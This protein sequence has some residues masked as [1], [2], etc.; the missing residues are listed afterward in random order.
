MEILGLIVREHRTP[1][2]RISKKKKNFLTFS[3]Y[4]TLHFGPF[5]GPFVK[6]IRNFVL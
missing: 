3:N 5:C 4:S 1:E 2:G 6:S